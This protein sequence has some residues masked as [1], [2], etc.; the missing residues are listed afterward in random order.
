[1]TYYVDYLR[2]REWVFSL[3]RWSGGRY[4]FVG[5]SVGEHQLQRCVG[6]SRIC[7]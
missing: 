2:M 6:I 7:Y 1:M 4:K 3:Q 5:N